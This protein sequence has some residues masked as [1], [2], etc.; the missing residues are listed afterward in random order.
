M[1]KRSCKVEHFYRKSKHGESELGIF[2][3]E[4]SNT[5]QTKLQTEVNG[6]NG[7]AHQKNAVE[8]HFL[9]RKR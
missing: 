7:D 9:R 6:E 3:E 5:E 1:K 8:G 2:F 4:Y